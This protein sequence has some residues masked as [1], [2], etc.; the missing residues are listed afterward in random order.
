MSLFFPKWLLPLIT[1]PHFPQ[2]L[3]SRLLKTLNKWPK[4]D[5]TKWAA[6][7]HVTSSYD[8]G[9]V[10]AVLDTSHTS[11]TWLQALLMPCLMCSSPL[12]ATLSKL[13]MKLYAM[14]LFGIDAD[15]FEMQRCHAQCCL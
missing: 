12:I 1:T 15:A 4:I 7:S 5:R 13:A 9:T 14:I 8:V 3:M 6:A 2:S 10:D 11:H